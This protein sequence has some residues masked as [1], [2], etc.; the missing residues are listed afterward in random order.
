M[1]MPGRGARD[2]AAAPPYRQRQHEAAEPGA[3]KH[4]CFALWRYIAQE[5]RCGAAQQEHRKQARMNLLLAYANPIHACRFDPPARRG[6]FAIKSKRNGQAAE[7]D[8]QRDHR[9]AQ[10]RIAHARPAEQHVGQ[11]NVGKPEAQRAVSWAVLEAAHHL[12]LHAEDRH[13]H[14]EHQ[15]SI[16]IAYLRRGMLDMLLEGGARSLRR[17]GERAPGKQEGDQHIEPEQ[18]KQERLGQS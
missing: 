12:V 3:A 11:E 18:R 9:F 10:Q 15:R 8:R 2:Q 5:E 17:I 7:N 13:R 16:D 1:Q 14:A 4:A 6:P